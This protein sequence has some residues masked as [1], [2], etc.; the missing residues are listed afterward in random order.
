MPPL[1]AD[2]ML[3]RLVLGRQNRD[4]VSGDLLEEYREVILPERGL[5]GANRWY[6]MQVGSYIARSHLVWAVLFAGAFLARQAYDA[7]VPTTE[8][9]QRS[10]VTTYTAVILLLG[11]GYWAAWRSG[12]MLAGLLAGIAITAIAAVISIVGGAVLL[13]IW[14]D[15][16]TLAAIRNSG[17]V[18]EMFVLPI[19]A[20]GLGLV[21]GTIGGAVGAGARRVTR[22]DL[23]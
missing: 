19:F 2:F 22:I 16:A 5:Q 7:F 8:F 6:V 20:I 11:G 12:S 4:T 1:W 21:L 10:A 9:Y 13:A 18:E 23:S 14:H 3:R 17:G 15:A